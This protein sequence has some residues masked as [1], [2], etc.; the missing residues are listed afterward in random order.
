MRRGTRSL[1]SGWIGI[2]RPRIQ[3]PETA[4][5]LGNG[6][7]SGGFPIGHDSDPPNSRGA[8]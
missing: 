4:G 7:Q 6:R 5:C 2:C 3:T 8:G 1:A